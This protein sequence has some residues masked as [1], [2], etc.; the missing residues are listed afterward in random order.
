MTYKNRIASI[1][2]K[3]KQNTGCEVSTLVEN[4]TSILNQNR[5]IEVTTSSAKDKAREGRLLPKSNYNYQAFEQKSICRKQLSRCHATK[6]LPGKRLV[7]QKVA[8]RNRNIQVDA[9]GKKISL[10]QNYMYLGA[11]VEVFQLPTC[12]HLQS[13]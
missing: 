8:Q 12:W 3:C 7:C 2:K 11:T 1:S 13:D 5:T 4:S 10:P 9:D 6:S